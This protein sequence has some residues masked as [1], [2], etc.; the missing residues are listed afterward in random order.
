M[1]WLSEMEVDWPFLARSISFAVMGCRQPPRQAIHLFLVL[2]SLIQSIP[3]V[4][5]TNISPIQ[6]KHSLLCAMGMKQRRMNV[7]ICELLSLRRGRAINQTQFNSLNLVG[8]CATA[9]AAHNS[10]W[11]LLFSSSLPK[12]GSEINQHNQSLLFIQSLM[13]ERK[14]WLVERMNGA[15]MYYNSTRV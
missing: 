5:S 3:F 7:L 2:F 15:R 9:P 10:L 8:W 13:I 11:E 12:K 6:I 1:V 4:S 14:R